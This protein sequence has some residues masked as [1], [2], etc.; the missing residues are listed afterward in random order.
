MI[1]S[2]LIL[3]NVS[4][5]CSF[6]SVASIT[7]NLGDVINRYTYDPFENIV[8]KMET[9][10]NM[11]L[12]NGQWGVRALSEFGDI[13]IMRSRMYHA[14]YGKF[15]HIVLLGKAPTCTVIYQTTQLQVTNLSKYLIKT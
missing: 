12:Y 1:A 10:E 4:P 9:V 2:S 5:L 15:I 7:N 13:Y 8:E 6:R 14:K 3:L 11:F